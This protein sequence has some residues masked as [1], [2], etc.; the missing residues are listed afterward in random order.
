MNFSDRLKKLR[1]RE[2][3]SREGLAG[4]IEVSYSTIAKY[5]SGTREPDFSTLDKLSIFF[6]VDT[7]YLLGRTD[8]PKSSKEF[9]SLSEI[10]KIVDEYGIEDMF[11]H[12][13][14][15]WKNL[16]P[17]DVD[18]LRNHF[19]YIAYKARKRK[20]KEDND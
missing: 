9:D 2:N 5:E 15:D 18:E 1:N 7:D 20:E 8:T 11:F 17:E 14:D 10:K 13:M 16:T 4:K 6:N 19:E 3:L 12:N